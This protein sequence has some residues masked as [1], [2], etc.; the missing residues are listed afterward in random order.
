MVTKV[1]QSI[2]DKA[3]NAESAN[4]IGRLD[5]IVCAPGCGTKCGVQWMEQRCM[6]EVKRG[7]R[8]AWENRVLE[9]N[10]TVVVNDTI[11]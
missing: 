3:R 4:G 7:K 6:S 8:R 10:C 1:L 2:R 9:C 5:V 11:Q